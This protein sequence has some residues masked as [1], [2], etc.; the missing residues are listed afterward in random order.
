[1]VIEFPDMDAV[2]HWHNSDDYKPLLDK[3]HS[4][5]SF[6]PLP[7]GAVTPNWGVSGTKRNVSTSA[8][9]LPTDGIAE[10]PPI[11]APGDA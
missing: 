3:R 1:M 7:S 5:L 4:V 10:T 2:E 8:S 11:R 6:I 9:E